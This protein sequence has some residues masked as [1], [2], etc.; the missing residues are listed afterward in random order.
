MFLDIVLDLILV[1]WILDLIL[2]L[3]SNSLI[4]F[5]ISINPNF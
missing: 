1:I 3:I 5:Q 4:F 2:A